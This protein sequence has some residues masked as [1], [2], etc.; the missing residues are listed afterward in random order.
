MATAIFEGA[1]GRTAPARNTAR[2]ALACLAAADARRPIH[3]RD[4]AR[5]GLDDAGVASFGAG[6][7]AREC[8]MRRFVRL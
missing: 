3:G 2:A 1:G 7:E 6:H 8:L 4:A 5:L